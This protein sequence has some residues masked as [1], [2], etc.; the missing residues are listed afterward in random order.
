MKQDEFDIL[1]NDRTKNIIGDISWS[2]DEDHSPVVEFRVEVQS[3]AGYPVFIRGSFNP[4]IEALSYN[5]IHRSSG[6]IYGLDIGKDHHNPSC[7]NIGDIHKHKWNESLRDKEAYIPNDI[8]IE[9][10]IDPVALW[11]L[12]CIE[13]NINHDGVLHPPS[14]SMSSTGTVNMGAII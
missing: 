13:A 8:I 11:K 7:V 5:I 9:G 4:L 2:E 6:R 10:E 3:D 12:F 1:L 14:S